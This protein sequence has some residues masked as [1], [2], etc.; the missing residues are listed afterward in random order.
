MKKHLL[1]I[2]FMAATLSAFAQ[3]NIRWGNTDVRYPMNSN[4]LLEDKAVTQ[5]VA[6][7]GERVNL[8]LVVA[9]GENYK[10]KPNWQENYK[11][12]KILTDKLN[13]LCPGIC[14]G[15]IFKDKRFNQH[16]SDSC[17]LIEMGNEKNTLMQVEAS[18][19]LVSLAFSQ[20]F[21]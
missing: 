13:E 12:A 14:K 18:A 6:W 17:L 9:N 2:A 10:V 4:E 20:V 21:N 1:V 3:M 7:R 15:I 11:L 16:V 19:S 5:V 8:Q